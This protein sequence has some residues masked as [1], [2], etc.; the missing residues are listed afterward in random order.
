MDETSKQPIAVIFANMKGNLGDFA[1][2]H[3]MLLGLG[4]KNPGT[5]IHVYSHPMRRD[6][7]KRMEAF[8][9]AAP[10]YEY[11]GPSYGSKPGKLT[12]MALK[13]GV[14]PG[15]LAAVIRASAEK[16][17]KDFRSFSKY[18]AVYVAG[19]EQWNGRGL[20]ALMFASLK[21]L[22]GL[23]VPVYCFPFSIKP[24]LSKLY[25]PQ[26]IKE[27]FSL[28][29]EPLVVR[30]VTSAD[31]LAKFGVA[32]AVGADSVF[33]LETEVSKIPPAEGRDASRVLLAVTGNYA[34]IAAAAST[35]KSAGYKVEAI[36]TCEIE[37]KENLERLRRELGVGYWAPSTWQGFVSEVKASQ[38][39]VTNRLHGVILSVLSGS[40]LYPVTDRNKVASFVKDAR[41]KHYAVSLSALGETQIADALI[42]RQ[43]TLRL[44]SAYLEGRR[45]LPCSPLRDAEN[46]EV[47]VQIS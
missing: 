34:N 36:T 1:I 13:L 10:T 15:G 16:W 33:A 45:S 44:T 42:A 24:K 11:C 5:S 32:S 2:L 30:D 3:A 38:L 31:F 47:H 9:L 39:V 28:L 8:R 4:N 21:A 41:I 37:D 26:Q 35:L 29:S 14:L 22:R 6:D 27:L 20:G 43:D 40:L 18:S 17:T 12:M 19:G 25:S 46:G 7:A 23:G